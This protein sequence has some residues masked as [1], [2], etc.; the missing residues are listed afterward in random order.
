MACMR[1]R[2][3]GPLLVQAAATAVVVASMVWPRPALGLALAAAACAFVVGTRRRAV[4]WGAAAFLLGAAGSVVVGVA[5]DRPWQ[6]GLSALVFSTG[7]LGVPWLCGL[8][9]QLVQRTRRQ[10]AAHAAEL[11]RSRRAAERLALAE[12]LH[13]E[14]GHSLSLVALTLARLEVDPSMSADTRASVGAARSRLSEAVAR[15]GE[16]VSTLRDGKAVPPPRPAEFTALIQGAR[17]AGAEI[18]LH[19]V[20]QLS[21]VSGDGRSLL[22]RVLQEALTNAARHAPGAPVEVEVSVAASGTTMVVRNRNSPGAG[23]GEPSSGTGLASLSDHVGNAGGWLDSGVS[24]DGFTVEVFLPGSVDPSAGNLGDGHG[25]PVRRTVAAILATTAAVALV[26]LGGLQVFSQGMR[27]EAVMGAEDFARIHPGDPVAELQGLLPDRELSPRPTAAPGTEC[28][29]Y[30]V[31]A[32]LF[33]DEAGDAYRICV[34]T[35][36]GTVTGADV[37]RGDRR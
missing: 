12:N 16:S 31:T 11:R 35:D 34:S 7:S 24:G 27:K 15:L 13:D 21:A 14:L 26:V 25:R 19:G 29:D 23:P 4:A 6:D 37:V 32:S 8:A 33:D 28:R 1:R 5:T 3:R 9:V 36:T 10:A 18:T 22:S 30:A 2:D 20:E 17:E